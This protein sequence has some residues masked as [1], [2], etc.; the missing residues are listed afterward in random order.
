MRTANGQVATRSI[1][2]LLMDLNGNGVTSLDTTLGTRWAAVD[3]TD[4]VGA[5]NIL[6]WRVGVWLPD[7]RSTLVDAIDPELLEG[8]VGCDLC[9][10]EGS[11][12]EDGRELHD[13]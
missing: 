5:V 4:H 9:C 6:D 7:T 2:G 12:G 11:D 8:S 13:C 1:A 10:R 3:V